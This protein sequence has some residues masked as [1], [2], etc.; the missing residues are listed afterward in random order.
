[1]SPSTS[2]WPPSTYRFDADPHTYDAIEV[3]YRHPPRTERRVAFDP[4]VQRRADPDGAKGPA[5]LCA[6]RGRETAARDARERYDREVTAARER[7]DRE[8]RELEARG[9][10]R[11]SLF[12]AGEE[13]AESIGGGTVGDRE[14]AV[15]EGGGREAAVWERYVREMREAEAQS[16]CC[17]PPACGVVAFLRKGSVRVWDTGSHTLRDTGA[18]L[19]RTHALFMEKMKKARSPE[20][21]GPPEVWSPPGSDGRC[22]SDTVGAVMLEEVLESEEEPSETEA[23][24]GEDPVSDGSE[25]IVPVPL[26]K[27]STSEREL[28]KTHEELS[29]LSDGAETEPSDKS[30]LIGAAP[31]EKVS[32][33]ERDMSKTDADLSELSNGEEPEETTPG[34]AESDDGAA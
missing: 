26:E 20:G 11:R 8:M 6:A 12:G 4:A 13:S 2:R 29:E 9:S 7:Y 10:H 15:R 17:V 14:A 30:L 1:M 34:D 25:K 27:V 5:P 31:L 24:D 32:T 3:E 23:S 18:H 16:R 22:G 21:G 33:S 19:S 28:S